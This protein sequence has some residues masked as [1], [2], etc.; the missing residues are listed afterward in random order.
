MDKTGVER[1]EAQVLEPQMAIREGGKEKATLRQY[2]ISVAFYISCTMFCRSIVTHIK[3]RMNS[4]GGTFISSEQLCTA[5]ELCPQ[6][7]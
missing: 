6:A 4:P 2:L 1:W 3:S 7:R 5:A